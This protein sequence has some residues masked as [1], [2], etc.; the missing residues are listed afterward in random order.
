MTSTLSTIYGKIPKNKIENEY[1]EIEIEEQAG[2]R[3]GRSTVEHRS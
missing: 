3:A 2:F 1:K